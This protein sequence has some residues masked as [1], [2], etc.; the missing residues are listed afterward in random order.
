[1]ADF[2]DPDPIKVKYGS[3]AFDDI[4]AT[5]CQSCTSLG[6]GAVTESR[7]TMKS[8]TSTAGVARTDMLEAIALAIRAV[9]TKARCAAITPSSLLLE[10]LALDSL[11][12]VAVI[13]DLQDQF[14]VE[15][16]PD[17][18]PQLRTVADLAVSVANQLRL[19]A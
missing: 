7:H 17:E 3:P 6:S 10:E 2:L 19:A 15:I 1:M 5:L 14:Q 4:P 9:S 16:D 8:S 11:D 12:L 18:I 13:L